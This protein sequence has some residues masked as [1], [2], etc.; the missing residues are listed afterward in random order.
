MQ[1]S[2]RVRFQRVRF[3]EFPYL[4]TFSADADDP[5]TIEYKIG[6][7][8]TEIINR[9]PATDGERAR[10]AVEVPA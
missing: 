1:P 8:F 2:L 5:D 4:K 7:I 9:F 10:A 3:G 6:E